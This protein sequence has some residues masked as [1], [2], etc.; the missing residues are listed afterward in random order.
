MCYLEAN[1]MH[2]GELEHRRLKRFYVRTNK[3]A[4]FVSQIA[5]HQRCERFV[6]DP[7]RCVPTAPHRKAKARRLMT[8]KDSCPFTAHSNATEEVPA[9]SPR[10]HHSISRE[11]RTHVDIN[12][13]VNENEDDPAFEAC[14][15][16][17]IATG[18]VN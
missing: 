9:C 15:V 8:Q 13:L 14:T 18:Q 3:N 4:L 11:Q 1:G 2:Q 6:N 5:S 7:R 17:L 12:A 16:S 10:D